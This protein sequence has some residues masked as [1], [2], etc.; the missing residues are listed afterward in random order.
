MKLFNYSGHSTSHLT[1]CV[2]G[3]EQFDDK[4]PTSLS[5]ESSDGLP[6]HESY[7]QPG[8]MKIGNTTSVPAL[9]TIHH[10]FGAQQQQQQHQQTS[11]NSKF[12]SSRTESVHSSDSF[13][14]PR[15]GLSSGLSVFP[16]MVEVSEYFGSEADSER[17]SISPPRS[18]QHDEVSHTNI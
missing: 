13:S 1:P 12:G 4:P 9:N 17:E 6:P 3:L 14:F 18:N 11:A 7:I 10:S 2:R 8:K 5:S 16:K 15:S